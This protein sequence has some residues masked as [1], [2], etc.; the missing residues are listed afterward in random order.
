MQC[1]RFFTVFLLIFLEVRLNG[2][3]TRSNLTFKSNE[4]LENINELPETQHD[5]NDR[6]DS[7]VYSAD[8]RTTE[9][10][11]PGW[12]AISSPVQMSGYVSTKTL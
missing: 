1:L 10:I 9:D 5:S 6:H 8:N 2:A 7:V 12:N 4:G 11:K 3:D